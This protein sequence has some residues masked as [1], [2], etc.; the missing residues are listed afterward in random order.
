MQ[1][2][3]PYKRMFDMEYLKET[4]KD[5]PAIQYYCGEE[6]QTAI[7][8]AKEMKEKY[9][10][11]F[12]DIQAFLNTVK[13]V[14][15]DYGYVRTWGGRKRHF[16]NPSKEA[17]KAPNALIQGSCGDIL[18]VKLAELEEFLANKKTRV[19]NTVHDSILFE[20]DKEEFKEGIV[21]ELVDLLRDLPFRVP[22]DWEAEGSTV[23]W[24]D[25]KDVKTI[26]LNKE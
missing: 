16:A 13:Q 18:K 26:D 10:S 19:I 1:D 6:A 3:V 20:V 8:H 2:K 4:Y 23:S 12:P 9:F 21:D 22:M 7:T 25:I 17:Y 11:Q 15:K 5:N 14:A 24:A